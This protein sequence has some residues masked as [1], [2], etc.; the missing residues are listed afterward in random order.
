MQSWWTLRW[1]RSNQCLGK[2]CAPSSPPRTRRTGCTTRIRGAAIATSSWEATAPGKS[3]RRRST[4][5]SS[6]PARRPTAKKRERWLARCAAASA[7]RARRCASYYLELP[8][9]PELPELLPALV[10]EPLPAP[11]GAAWLLDDEPMDEGDEDDEPVAALP[12]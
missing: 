1:R 11:P 12:E 6:L 5:R 9:A 3:S 4:T 10:L 8:L 7:P 2:A